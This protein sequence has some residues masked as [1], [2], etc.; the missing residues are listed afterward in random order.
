MVLE[1]EFRSEKE[2]KKGSSFTTPPFLIN[3][4]FVGIFPRWGFSSWKLRLLPL[5][6][7]I[8]FL[9]CIFTQSHRKKTFFFFF[10]IPTWEVRNGKSM[11]HR[12]LTRA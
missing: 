9:I 4:V 10:F 3:A 12:L 2:R 1:S 7:F 5:H 8:L 11:K 6:L